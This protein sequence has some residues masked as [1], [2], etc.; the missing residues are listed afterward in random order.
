VCQQGVRRCVPRRSA[1]R[2]RDA[3]RFSSFRCANFRHTFRRNACSAH[4]ATGSRWSLK[5]RRVRWRDLRPGSG[6]R[7]AREV[8]RA[9]GDVPGDSNMKVTTSPASSAFIVMMSSLSAHFSILDCGVK[10]KDAERS[11]QRVVFGDGRRTTAPKARYRE[12]PGS[13]KRRASRDSSSALVGEVSHGS[14]PETCGRDRHPRSFPDGCL[15]REVSSIGVPTFKQRF[16]QA[17]SRNAR[18]RRRGKGD[19]QRTR[20][21]PK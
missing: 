13:V 19:R 18:C 3:G 7:V 6:S 20:N 9:I 2:A 11:G 8:R 15:R 14:V 4:L 1:P 10:T 17:R 21:P 12:A 16:F 5:N